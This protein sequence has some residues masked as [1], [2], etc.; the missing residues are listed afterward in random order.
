MTRAPFKTD[1]FATIVVAVLLI[2]LGLVL[3]DWR[4]HLVLHGY[5]HAVSLGSLPSWA[6]SGWWPWV[7]ALVTIILG[8]LGLWWLLAHAQRDTAS[9]VKMAQST[10]H[11][12]ITL[13]TS[14]LADAM[15]R[16]LE[17]A[18]PF[19]SVKGTAT[20]LNRATTVVLTAQLDEY[21]DGPSV[22]EAIGGLREQ[23]ASAFPDQGVTAR[24]LLTQARS[25]RRARPSSNSVRVD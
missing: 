11:G 12:T 4:Y 24:V 19:A 15:A 25:A 8:L 10:Q 1:R 23:L 20:Q 2:V 5:P 9:S 14:S 18:G 3:I 17:Q 13:D 6:G 7:F 21:A 22:T 16:S